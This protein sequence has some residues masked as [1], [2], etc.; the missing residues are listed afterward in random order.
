MKQTIHNASQFRDAFRALGRENQFSYEAFDLLF[1]YLEECNSDM[2]LDVIAICC[3]YS[4]DT[5]ENIA[6]NY[7]IDLSAA[8]DGADE[9]SAYGLEQIAQAELDIVLDYL[10]NHTS[11][12]GETPSGIVYADF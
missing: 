6:G 9:A 4:E 2:T 3:D 1:D 11:V 8:R 7:D 12:V 5:V 10:N